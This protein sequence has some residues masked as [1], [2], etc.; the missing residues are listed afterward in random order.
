MADSQS[1]TT[2][3]VVTEST[4]V[5]NS[6]S[7]C[8]R[9]RND[10]SSKPQIANRSV[11]FPEDESLI[12]T[13]YLEPANPWELAESSDRDVVI[14]S[15]IRS[16]EKH[17]TK[18]IA[19]IIEQLQMLD[20]GR[21]RADCL[22][23]KD[24]PLMTA[25]CEP[26]EEIL[27]R[28][29]FTKL[30]LEATGLDDE[31]AVVL[32]DMIE[33]YEAAVH[34]NI[35]SNN[36]I[37]VRGWQACSGML[38]R[39]KSLEN[40][41]CRNTALTE[42]YMPI[43]CK[44][45]RVGTQL[46][47][48][49]LENCGLGGRSIVILVAALKLNTGLKE[50]YLAENYLATN[51]AMQLG[52]L[53]K[54]NSTLQLLD[55]SNN[56]VEDTGMS[57]LCDGLLEQSTPG[58]NILVVWNNNLSTDSAHH[59]ARALGKNKTLEMLNIGH[60]N[61]GND[62]FHLTKE[63]LLCNRSLLRLGLQATQQTCEGAIA[64][65]EIIE[66]NPVIQRIDLRDNKMELAGMMA[67]A[68][69]MKKNT[70]ITQLD[71]D[72]RPRN[73]HS[74]D[75]EKYM[76]LVDEIRGYCGRNESAGKD[77]EA[78]EKLSQIA[79]RKISLT[80]DTLMQQRAMTVPGFHNSR[81]IGGHST[82]LLVEPRRSSGGRLRSPAPSPIP[83]PVA[84]P[85]PT[86]TRFQVSKVSEDSPPDT[87]F[88]GSSGS[89]F[90][91]TVVEPEV[92][93]PKKEVHTEAFVDVKKANSSSEQLSNEMRAE[94]VQQAA[95]RPGSGGGGGVGSGGPTRKLSS[96]VAPTSLFS[97]NKAVERLLGLFQNPFGRH[98]QQPQPQPMASAQSTVPEEPC[99]RQTSAA[100][101]LPDILN[102]NDAGG[103]S[104]ALM[105]NTHNQFRHHS[106]NTNFPLSTA[107][108]FLLQLFLALVLD[109]WFTD[110]T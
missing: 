17:G 60:N 6:L 40:L 32:F 91:V 66:D 24:E 54:C 39:T 97:E 47:V 102:N 28:I 34:L 9:A 98:Q 82:H 72:D 7:S 51:D 64:L 30:N 29:Q 38:K 107:T 33:Y 16:C 10:G 45:L 27:K 76:K 55:I 25:S 90:R 81:N 11:S 70:S 93:A 12:V 110:F 77:S 35:S 88:F 75:L 57:H 21:D 3:G 46:Q 73:K 65:A 106:R 36:G 105:V 50:L 83:S 62:F 22:T 59:L 74:L 100:P 80:C 78:R 63:A 103:S 79:A 52:A 14:S 53:L 94:R 61:L 87:M 31:A 26:L 99:D 58:L 56:K 71:L 43:I 41:E 4:L 109:K 49:R 108:H 13:G 104:T 18:P 85:S 37:G 69:S 42:Q 96:W 5:L 89:R 8:L 95:N 2:F 68:L 86:R 44:A 19:S 84:S 101:A 92:I 20:I 1:N 48:L 67:L 23:L 15:Y